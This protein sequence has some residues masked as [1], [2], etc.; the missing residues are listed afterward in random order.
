M[1][2]SVLGF[3]IPVKPSNNNN[4]NRTL[5]FRKLGDCKICPH[6]LL[7]GFTGQQ[8]HYR[9]TGFRVWSVRRARNMYHDLRPTK[10]NC[11]M[12]TERS[13]HQPTTARSIKKSIRGGDHHRS[14]DIALWWPV[15]VA[16]RTVTRSAALS[17]IDRAIDHRTCFG[18]TNNYGTAWSGKCGVVVAITRVSSRERERSRSYRWI[19]HM[20][21][22]QAEENLRSWGF[23]WTLFDYDRRQVLHSYNGNRLDSTY[24]R[25][26]FA[27]KSRCQDGEVWNIK[28]IT[29]NLQ[30]WVSGIPIC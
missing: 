22:G 24:F 13:E 14:A 8:I 16:D 28:A 12:R 21:D 2:N 18:C 5:Y 3:P 27:D 20:I 4:T 1:A 10:T 9:A 11:A 17:G 15:L 25:N 26:R 19:M 7:G 23:M 30:R 29:I 6:W